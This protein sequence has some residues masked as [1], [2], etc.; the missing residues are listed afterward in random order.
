[1]AM[2]NIAFLLIASLFMFYFSI[3]ACS[4]EDQLNSMDGLTTFDGNVIAVDA[5]NS[6]LTVKGGTTAVFKI[7]TGTRIVKDIY[8]IKLS[9]IG[10][11]DYVSV[12]Y[13]PGDDGSADAVT[14]NVRYGEAN[15]Y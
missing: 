8:P 5:G 10:I 9:D 6:T 11:G 1:M 2:K 3:A 13:N 12:G 4:G 15:I 14:V 7:S